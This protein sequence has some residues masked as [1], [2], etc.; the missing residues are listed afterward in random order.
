MLW[1]PAEGQSAAGCTLRTS[2]NKKKKGF[3]APMNGLGENKYQGILIA[4][5][6]VDPDL[7]HRACPRQTAARSR[8]RLPCRVPQLSLAPSTAS[9][10]VST[11]AALAISSTYQ[12]KGVVSPQFLHTYIE[13]LLMCFAVAKSVPYIDKCCKACIVMSLVI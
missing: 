2:T 4:L 1:V 5:V 13:V 6:H 12:E 11:S 10:I 7:S 3:P 8:L 9:C